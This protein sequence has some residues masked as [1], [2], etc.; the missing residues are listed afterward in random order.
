MVVLGMTDAKRETS[1]G[2]VKSTSYEQRASLNENRKMLLFRLCFSAWAISAVCLAY[3]GYILLCARAIACYELALWMLPLFSYICCT[4]YC[5][6]KMKRSH[7]D[8][9]C[10][11]A[12]PAVTAFGLLML[13]GFVP[14]ESGHIIQA[15]GLFSRSANGF[16][17]P[18]EL[19]SQLPIDYSEAYQ[20]IVLPPSWTETT[21]TYTYYGSYS[22]LL[23]FVPGIVLKISKL[24]NLNVYVSLLAGRVANGLVYVAISALL[25]N[26]LTKFKTVLFVFLMNPMLL[27][28]EAS[29]SA[30]AIS[31]IV[32]IAY[33]VVVLE[34]VGKSEYKK[35]DALTVAALSLGLLMAKGM[36]APLLLFNLL[37]LSR[38]MSDKHCL[39][40]YSI[41]GLLVCGLA[42]LVISCYQGPFM[43][44]SFEL[45]RQP[46]HCLKVLAKTLWELGPFY[47]ETYAGASLGPLTIW[48]WK[49]WFWLYACLQIVCLFYRDE[50]DGIKL[51]RPQSALVVIAVIVNAFL[52]ILTQRGW[53]LTVDMREDIICGAQGRYFIPLVLP[54]LAVVSNKHTGQT[55]GNVLLMATVF[56][57]L[58]IMI[59][60]VCIVGYFAL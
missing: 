36:F 45:M 57:A 46:L 19:A 25:F 8:L 41:V 48:V 35:R 11:V 53:S 39:T 54:L 33:V 40:V 21:L 14:D 37:F 2:D 15:A 55:G 52:I 60:F 32:A 28:Q 51:G 38:C 47:I 29:C 13:P 12:I 9:Y 30:D 16:Y 4:A 59:D 23:Y 50:S 22:D 18:S 10:L 44:Y 6:V 5:A 24:L 56:L 20:T 58:I 42:V 43:S 17:V 34:L 7:L 1:M 3:Y 49:P 27:Q 26:Y 31:N